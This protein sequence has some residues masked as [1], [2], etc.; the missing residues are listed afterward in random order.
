MDQK[1]GQHAPKQTAAQ[2]FFASEPDLYFSLKKLLKGVSMLRISLPA[3]GVLLPVTIAHSFSSNGAM[4][5]I[6]SEMS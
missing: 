1:G 3:A 4:G 6:C 2:S 5:S